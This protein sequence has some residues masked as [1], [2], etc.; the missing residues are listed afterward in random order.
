[1][2]DDMGSG[3]ILFSTDFPHSDSKFPASVE[4]F[5]EL[6]INDE[7]KRKI[8]WDNCIDLYHL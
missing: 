7:A 4:R 6:D 2:V 8:L 3:N 5:L 1:V